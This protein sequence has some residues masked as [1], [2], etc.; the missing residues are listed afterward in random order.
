MRYDMI[1]IKKTDRYHPSHFSSTSPGQTEWLGNSCQQIW[2]PSE[3]LFSAL[4][5]TCLIICRL[6]RRKLMPDSIVDWSET[7]QISNQHV[8]LRCRHIRGQKAPCNHLSLLSST[9][10]MAITFAPCQYQL[11]CSVLVLCLQ[12]LY[13]IFRMKPWCSCSWTSVTI[14]RRHS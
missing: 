4:L 10:A 11:A 7:T 1:S 2:N 8:P 5:V 6:F 9:I 14:E 13:L 3:P 12:L